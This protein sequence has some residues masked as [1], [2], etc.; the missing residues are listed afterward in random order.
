M[1]K[2]E[3]G[4]TNIYE[5]LYK[6][7]VTNYFIETEMIGIHSAFVKN[8]TFLYDVLNS[9]ITYKTN[10]K[11]Y[12]LNKNILWNNVEIELANLVLQRVVK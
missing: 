2:V 7:R 4:K 1:T 9:R 12:I 3:N 5:S 8:E 6:N 11:R 10:N